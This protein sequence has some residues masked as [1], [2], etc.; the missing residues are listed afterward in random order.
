MNHSKR[1]WAACGTGALALAVAGGVWFSAQNASLQHEQAVT[2]YQSAARVVAEANESLLNKISSAQA[3]YDAHEA[4]IA[5]SAKYNLI[6]AIGDA[7]L[8]LVRVEEMPQTTDEIIAAAE[9]LEAPVD[10]SQEAARLQEASEAFEA[11]IG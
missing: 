4:S 9:K 1:I 7:H 3:L 2:R 6:N 11:L 10:F 5:D 8:A